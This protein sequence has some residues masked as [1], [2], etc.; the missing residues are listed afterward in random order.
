MVIRRK[1]MLIIFDENIGEWIATSSLTRRKH[2]GEN[3]E[4]AIAICEEDDR[5]YARHHRDDMGEK[6]I[7]SKT[8]GRDI[9]K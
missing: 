7:G 8:N 2:Y 6:S 4:Q 3:R 1:E 5:I 9:S